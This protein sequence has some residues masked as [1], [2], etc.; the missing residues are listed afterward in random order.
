MYV[1]L[2]VRNSVV[3]SDSEKVKRTGLEHFRLVY[4]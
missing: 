2:S 1:I 4:R 3:N